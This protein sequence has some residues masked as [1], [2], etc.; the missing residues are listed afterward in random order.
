MKTPVIA[1]LLLTL[2]HS[3]RAQEKVAE[4]GE[5]NPTELNLKECPFERG[6]AAMNLLKTGKVSM[7]FHP[8]SG[9]L[10]LT[11]AYRVRIKIFDKRGFSAA[12]VKIPYADKGR[13]T[14]VKDI[15]AY[16]YSL[17]ANG[18][19]ARQR[20]EKKEIFQNKSRAKGALNYIS[21]TF[22]DLYDGAVL[23]YR[24]TRITKNSLSI[25]P[26]FFQD[27]IPTAFSKVVTS[28][29]SYAYLD[30]RAIATDKLE[31]DSA[32]KRYS[33]SIYDEDILSFTLRNVHSFRPE[34]LMYSLSDNLERLE[35]SLSPRTFLH[36]SFLSNEAKMKMQGFSLLRSPFFGD[37]FGKRI[38]GADG[39]IDS[40]NKLPRKRDKVAACFA[41]IRQN[42]QFNGEQTF[43]CDSV[44]GCLKSRS[45]SSAQM[46]I[47][48]LNLLRKVGVNCVP[49]LVSTHEN[50]NPDLDFPSISQF[51]GVDVM[52]RDST[53][54]YIIDCTQKH[55]SFEMPPYNVLNSEAYIVDA[56]DPQWIFILDSRILA[57]SETTVDAEMD[58]TGIL[59]G[60]ARIW[61]I[62][63][64]KDKTL[65]EYDRREE[66]SRED[67]TTEGE[68]IT[69]LA[70]DTVSMENAA[71][72]G[73]TLVRN[74]GFH[75]TPA[76]TGNI[77]FFNPFLFLEFRKNPFIDSVRYSDVD[78]GCNQSFSTR[79]RIK[80][81]ANF[82]VDLLPA[83]RVLWKSDSSISFIKKVFKEG[84]YLVIESSFLMKNSIFIKEDYV[85]LKSFF[86]KFY[87]IQNEEIPLIKS[88]GDR[89]R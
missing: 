29:P 70:I 46:N 2:F 22:P 30:Y 68:T 52:V 35:F 85:S 10:T 47:L 17:D 16:I 71:G 81:A 64:A 61:D 11:T 78:F 13:S 40:V 39:L 59:N 24:Y 42:V 23:E 6:A 69:G 77:Y 54:S 38:E 89:E 26:W 15:E 73:D 74:I 18:K 66:K 72:T 44:D 27:E 56:A 34:P 55:L 28:I 20:V 7:E 25:Q 58:S 51:N 62:G 32:F 60:K 84:K 4:F 45:G 48:L 8:N 33:N 83:D 1:C 3:A 86:D 5:I 65:E 41:Y 82:S 37:Q 19:V 53:L 12:E 75:Y 76:S 67:K 49:L 88:K 36:S 79:V 63:F 80:L 14:R 57:K 87:A 9:D 21:F 50:G 43:Y 31:K